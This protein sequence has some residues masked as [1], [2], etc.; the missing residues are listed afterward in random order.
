MASFSENNGYALAKRTGLLVHW[1][2]IQAF[3]GIVDQVPYVACLTDDST[4]SSR[5]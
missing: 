4:H 3:N 2:I 5:D 1:I